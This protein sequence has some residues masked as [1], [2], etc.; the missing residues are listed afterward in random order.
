[1]NGITFA[2]LFD[3][4]L[5]EIEFTERI[6]AYEYKLKNG[7]PT[8][9]GTPTGFPR[10]DD[11]TEGLL[12]DSLFTITGRTAVGKSFAATQIAVNVA[13][14]GIPVLYF[15]TDMSPNMMRNRFLSYQSG[16]ALK[17]I[18]YHS[19]NTAERKQI[20]EAERK[21][22]EQPI[23]VINND[24]LDY[25]RQ[26]SIRHRA[27]DSGLGLIVV[28]C[29][30]RVYI[31]DEYGR[32]DYESPRIA[33]ELRHLAEELQVPIIV[34]SK[35]PP[36]VEPD[37]DTSQLKLFQLSSVIVVIARADPS[38]VDD[39]YGVDVWANQDEFV[40][41]KNHNGPSRVHIPVKPMLDIARFVE[42]A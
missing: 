16:V 40:I 11:K 20:D 8:I 25:I 38:V 36:A 19:Y 29:L 15:S 12:P 32:C 4:A 30:Q 14:Q 2:E 31:T 34:V 28:D 42:L 37:Y 13:L 10:L 17:K 33:F 5:I 24:S 26:E 6:A 35:Q 9:T 3:P 7:L 41:V 1:M 39:Y 22:R 27:S 18:D 23:T 21:L